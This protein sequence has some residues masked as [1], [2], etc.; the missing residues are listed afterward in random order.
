MFSLVPF[1]PIQ[2]KQAGFQM[3]GLDPLHIFLF[4]VYS[5]WIVD[6]VYC[7]VVQLAMDDCATIFEV[8]GF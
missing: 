5:M 8:G 6:Y 3:K 1:L 2:F 7:I 4:N